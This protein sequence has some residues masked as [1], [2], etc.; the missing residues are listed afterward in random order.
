MFYSDWQDA[1]PKIESAYMDG[2]N[3]KRIITTEIGAP[4]GLAIDKIEQR[5]YWSDMQLDRIES[6]N[7]QGTDRRILFDHDGFN[8]GIPLE[9]VTGEIQTPYGLTL[10]RDKV[11]WTDWTRKAVYSADKRI[12]GKIDYITSGLEKPMQAHA[13]S[14]KQLK[15]E[16]S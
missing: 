13:Y 8:P 4:S 12:G 5:L 3:R 9:S 16:L 2:T 11:F 14:K 7:L 10:H 1:S 15:G 6:S